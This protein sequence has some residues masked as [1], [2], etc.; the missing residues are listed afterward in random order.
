MAVVVGAAGPGHDAPA[1]ALVVPIFAFETRAV[2]VRLWPLRDHAEGVYRRVDDR[3]FGGGPGMVM[4]VEPLVRCLSAIRA[5]QLGLSVA[6]VERAPQLGGTCLVW[7]CI[8]TKALLENAH[9]LKVA[10]EAAE[11]GVTGVSSPAID[12]ARVHARKNKIV[13]GLTKGIEFLF[14]KNNIEWI[15][16]SARLLGK[17]KVEVTGADA[18][19]L[20]AKAKVPTMPATGPLPNDPKKVKALAKDI[21]YPVMVKATWGGGGRGMRVVDS[22][23][24]LEA[25]YGEASREAA[26]AFGNGAVFI[27][28]F[29]RRPRHIDRSDRRRGPDHRAGKQAGRFRQLDGDADQHRVVPHHR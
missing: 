3:P 11:W 20:A 28:R 16:G 4:L 22:P 27:E 5:S 13:T 26:A 2:D 7:G 18:R 12:M 1:V 23:D 19:T 8:P 21:G 9:A 25:R 15:K 17:G 6:V 29:I 24:Q 10:Q 14:K